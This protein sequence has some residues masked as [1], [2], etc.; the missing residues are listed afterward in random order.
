MHLYICKTC[1]AYLDPGEKCDCRN[2]DVSSNAIRGE[3]DEEYCENTRCERKP[4]RN[5]TDC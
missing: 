4:G 5:E 2:E 3:P 1:G